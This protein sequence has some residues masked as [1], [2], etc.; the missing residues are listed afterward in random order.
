VIE[1]ALIGVALI[2]V[3]LKEFAHHKI[4]HVKY[5]WTGSLWHSNYVVGVI[6]QG[7][8]SLTANIEGIYCGNTKSS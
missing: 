5:A 2:E 1:V 8:E 6:A 7:A 3:A 4:A